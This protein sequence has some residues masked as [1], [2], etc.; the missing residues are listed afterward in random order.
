M[1]IDV[2]QVSRGRCAVLIG[3]ADGSRAVRQHGIHLQTEAGLRWRAGGRHGVPGG[4]LRN[5]PAFTVLTHGRRAGCGGDGRIVAEWRG[6]AVGAAAPSAPTGAQKQRRR[7]NGEGQA[8]GPGTTMVTRPVVHLASL[9]F[10]VQGRDFASVWKLSNVSVCLGVSIC[11][12][13]WRV[14]VAVTQRRDQRSRQP[15][16][17]NAAAVN[18]PGRSG[19][20]S[21]PGPPTKGSPSQPPLTKVPPRSASHITRTWPAFDQPTS[22]QNREATDEPKPH[23]IEPVR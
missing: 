16:A 13:I 6:A 11:F 19:F 1:P 2:E 17:A 10:M 5:R 23:F 3:G 8:K 20:V 4:A 7:Q 14:W 12:W 15:K 18:R 22:N 21:P 9:M